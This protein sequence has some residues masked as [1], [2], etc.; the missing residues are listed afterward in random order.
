MFYYYFSQKGAKKIST[1]SSFRLK[2]LF[3]IDESDKNEQE[4][5]K[6]AGT[7]SLKKGRISFFR[8]LKN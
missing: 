3:K 5:D 7:P 1:W 4:Y 6:E 2:F 8:F